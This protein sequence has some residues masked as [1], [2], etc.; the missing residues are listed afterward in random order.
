MGIFFALLSPLMFAISGYVDK[1]VLEK[2]NISSTSITVY[3]S[4]VTG[5]TGLLVLLFLGYYPIDTKSLIILLSS[6]ILLTIYLLLYYK[7]LSM[8]ETSRVMS[9]IQCYPIFILFLSYIFFHESLTTIQY[10]GSACMLVGGSLLYIEKIDGSIFKLRPSFYYVVA[11]A[12]TFSISQILYKFGV[13]EIPFWH[14]LPYEGFGIVLGAF[15]L[16]MYKSNSINV[17]AETKKLKKSVFLF[18]ALNELINISARYAGY[19]AISLIAVS[20]VSIVSEVQPLL[21]MIIGIILSVWFPKIIKEVINKKTL[22]IKAVSVLLVLLG[23][24]FIFS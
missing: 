4:I 9:L 23:S 20:I 1:F 5:I 10:V 6:G 19:F 2:H 18:V 22:R 16:L 3:N 13:E 12:F 24:Y 15:T 21:T 17:L 11:S 7:A 14:T 8:D